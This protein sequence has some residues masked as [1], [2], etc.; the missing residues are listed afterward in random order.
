MAYSIWATGRFYTK[1]SA[2]KINIGSRILKRLKEMDIDK[3][4]LKLSYTEILDNPYKYL[5]GDL[6]KKGDYCPETAEK[7][8]DERI[9]V[10]D[11]LCEGMEIEDGSEVVV[12]GIPMK[13]K[14][15]LEI[16]RKKDYDLIKHDSS[17]FD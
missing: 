7:I 17:R 4:D 5:S 9:Y 15:I 16:L 10:R 14:K 8:H 12:I 13:D 1:L 3:I 6:F 11:D 2:N